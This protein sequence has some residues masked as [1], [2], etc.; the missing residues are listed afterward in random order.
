MA[1]RTIYTP[2]CMKRKLAGVWR[3]VRN[4]LHDLYLSPYAWRKIRNELHNLYISPYAWRKIRNEL[5]NLYLSPYAIGII[6]EYEVAGACSTNGTKGE[7]LNWRYHQKRSVVFVLPSLLSLFRRTRSPRCLCV[8]VRISLPQSA[9]ECTN[10]SEGITASIFS[11]E[12]WTKQAGNHHEARG[13]DVAC[14]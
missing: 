8:Y 9:F 5:H 2:R 7:N 4:E 11:V 14:N 3:T 12:E 1:L 13:N 6:N 10:F